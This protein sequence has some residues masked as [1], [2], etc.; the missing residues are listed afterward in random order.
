MYFITDWLFLDYD[1]NLCNSKNNKQQTL[2]R[3]LPEGIGWIY[4]Q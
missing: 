2:P 3:N 1:F 4:E